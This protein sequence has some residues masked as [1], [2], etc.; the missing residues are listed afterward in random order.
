MSTHISLTDAEHS[1]LLSCLGVPTK[2]KYSLGSQWYSVNKYIK[3]RRGACSIRVSPYRELQFKVVPQ[4][5]RMNI[6]TT[7]L[8]TTKLNAK[9][10][11]MYNVTDHGCILRCIRNF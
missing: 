10:T 4:R 1:R 2:M 11:W 8:L 6:Q 9:R 7:C 5:A 3:M